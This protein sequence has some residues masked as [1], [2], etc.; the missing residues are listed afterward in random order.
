MTSQNDSTKLE[1]LRQQ[2]R[3]LGGDQRGIS[4]MGEKKCL[5]RLAQA[6]G[7]VTADSA[8]VVEAVAEP[9]VEETVRKKA[10]KMNISH[11]K[12]DDREAKVRELEAADPESK[13]IFQHHAVSDEAL[14]AKGFERTEHSVRNSILVRTDRKS[15][16]EYLEARNQNNLNG[17]KK[18]DKAEVYFKGHT[19]QPK[20]APKSN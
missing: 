16:E 2:V 12:V 6:E 9:V 20:E 19:A 14:A 10:P 18:I 11:I 15:Y 7:T 13:Y 3:E 17:M 1:A 8:E 5:E 4:N